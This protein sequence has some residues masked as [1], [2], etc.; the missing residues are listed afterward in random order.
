MSHNAMFGSASVIGKSSWQELEIIEDQIITLFNDYQPC[1]HCHTFMTKDRIDSQGIKNH[2]YVI[3]TC[4]LPRGLFV[5]T[6]HHSIAE[7]PFVSIVACFD[8]LSSNGT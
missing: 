2:P 6:N 3:K 7:S 8:C 5:W 4:I 1:S